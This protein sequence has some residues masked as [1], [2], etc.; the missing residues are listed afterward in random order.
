VGTPD[1]MSPE[2]CVASKIGP[3]TDVYA[4]GCMLFEMLTS[5]APFVGLINRVILQ[6]M[7]EPPPSPRE[8]RADLA[9][10]AE[11]DELCLRMLAK[12][13]EERPDISVVADVLDSVKDRPGR[14]RTQRYLQGRAARMVAAVSAPVRPDAA[15]ASTGRNDSPELAVFGRL[16]GDL[17]LGLGAMGLIPFVYEGGPLGD[18]QAI[19]APGASLERLSSLRS[20]HEVPLITDAKPKNMDRIAALVKLGVDEVVTDTATSSEV[21]RKV[22]RAIRRYRRRIGS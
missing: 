14:S 12:L 2:Q 21:A 19:F 18:A 10:P 4:L 5:R 7:F 6:H 15:F 9:I 3:P 11:L 13:P 17:L 1:Y 16:Q 20:T 8:L 22:W